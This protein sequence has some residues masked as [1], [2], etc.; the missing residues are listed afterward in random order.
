MNELG[1]FFELIEPGIGGAFVADELKIYSMTSRRLVSDSMR[2]ILGK[3]PIPGAVG[4]RIVPCLV[5]STSG[6]MTSSVQ[7]RRLAETSPGKV[8]FG[9]V[10]IA[11]L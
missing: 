10:D 1:L 8:K 6:S 11:I 2:S 4:T 5:T 3:Y 7:Y 9:S